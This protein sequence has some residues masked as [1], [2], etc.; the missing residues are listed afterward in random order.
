MG[1]IVQGTEFDINRETGR[2]LSVYIMY[3]LQRKLFYFPELDRLLT[4]LVCWSLN[5]YN[6]SYGKL[7]TGNHILYILITKTSQWENRNPM[8]ILFD[9]TRAHAESLSNQDVVS[10]INSYS[11]SGDGMLACVY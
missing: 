8:Y 10:I 1:R 2:S 11:V 7:V 3:Y 4:Q 5:E 9:V 6:R